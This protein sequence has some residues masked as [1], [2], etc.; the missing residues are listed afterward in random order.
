MLEKVKLA[1]RIKAD[2]YD[3]E[4]ADLI[5][6]AKADLALSGILQAKIDEEIDSLILRAVT[7][8]AKSH[9]GLFNADSEKYQR[10]YDSL[11]THLCLSSEY[12]EV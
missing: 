11:K 9:F 3:S 2:A 5:A 7:L 1:L 6:A 12:T 8:Y 10:A 4:L